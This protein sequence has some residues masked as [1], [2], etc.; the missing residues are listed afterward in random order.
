MT[1]TMNAVVLVPASRPWLAWLP[2]LLLSWWWSPRREFRWAFLIALEAGAL[3]A[4]WAYL[5]AACLA[6]WPEARPLVSVLWIAA[7]LLMAG[8]A[9]LNRRRAHAPGY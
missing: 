8:G 7:A 1:A 6:A 9:L 3:G 2:L 5:G 4:Q